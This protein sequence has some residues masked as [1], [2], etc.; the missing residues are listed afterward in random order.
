MRGAKLEAEFRIPYRVSFIQGVIQILVN[1]SPFLIPPFIT[2][3]LLKYILKESELLRFGISISIIFGIALYMLMAYRR[4]VVRI[5]NKIYRDYILENV[6][7]PACKA[8][9]SRYE[10]TYPLASHFSEYYYICD[11]CDRKYIIDSDLKNGKVVWKLFPE[12]DSERLEKFREIA[13][14]A[15]DEE[16]FM[17]SLSR[18]GIKNEEMSK[19]SREY[20]IKYGII[21]DMSYDKKVRRVTYILFAFYGLTGL[22]IYSYGILPVYILIPSISFMFVLTA[23]L[24]AWILEKK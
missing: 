23:A 22:L 5:S 3:I 16:E 10:R 20:K 11:L 18:L 17:S 19:L 21:R 2:F 6:P 1:C 7:C 9:L 15:H 14:E 8:K 24:S 4:D 12:S 13:E